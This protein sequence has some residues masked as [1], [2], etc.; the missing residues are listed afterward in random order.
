MEVSEVFGNGGYYELLIV[1][2]FLLFINGLIN[3]LHGNNE[4]NIAT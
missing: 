4:R 3:G 1:L 2:F